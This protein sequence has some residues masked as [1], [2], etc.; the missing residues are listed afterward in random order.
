MENIMKKKY[1]ITKDTVQSNGITLHRIKALHNFGDVKAFDTVKERDAWVRKHW[2]NENG[3]NIAE[4]ITYKDAR[5]ILGTGNWVE[6][7]G[8]M[9]NEKYDPRN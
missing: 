6:Y 9:I 1:E 2:C 4:N 5:D 8:W 7:E 3:N